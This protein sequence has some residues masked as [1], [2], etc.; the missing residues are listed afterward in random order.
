MKRQDPSALPATPRRRLLLAGLAATPAL[1]VA[2]R[3][4][5]TVAKPRAAP[6]APSAQ[7]G[8]HETEHIR[9][10]YRLAAF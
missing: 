2:M 7:G 6:P 8:Y 10:Y 9:T 5:D 3:A 1:A 4:G